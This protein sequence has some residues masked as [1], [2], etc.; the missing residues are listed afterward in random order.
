[1]N[2]KVETTIGVSLSKGFKWNHSLVVVLA[3]EVV[4]VQK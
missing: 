1:M 4:L 3:M 2:T